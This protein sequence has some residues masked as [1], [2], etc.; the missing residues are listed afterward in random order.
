VTSRRLGVSTALVDGQ[1]VAGDVA[2]ADGVVTDVGLPAARGGRIAAPGLI[3]LQVNGFAGVDL[4]TADTDGVREVATVLAGYGVT[5]WLPTLISA[6]SRD[7]EAALDVLSSVVPRTPGRWDG[8][9]AEPLGVHLEGP[10]LSPRRLG[11]HRPEHRR[12]PDPD[13]LSGWRR[14][15]PVLAVTLAPEL[16]GALDL[17]A[18]LAAD[19]VLVSVGHTDATAEQAHAAFDAGAGTVTHLF[20]AMS[21]LNHRAPGVPGAALARPDVVVQLIVDGHH[22]APD[23]VR[24]VW[25]A[26]AGRV[27]LVTDAIAAAGRP[28]QA[29]AQAEDEYVLA[30]MSVHVQD[31][32]VRNAEGALAGSAL[33]LDRAVRNACEL[34]VD[35]AAALTAATRTPADLIG[36]RDLGRLQPGARADLVVLDD[37]LAVQDTL[38]SGRLVR[39]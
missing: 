2:V 3:D 9:G 21:P 32:A 39:R 8:A 5:A 4:M 7:T 28:A 18:G 15:G 31:G 34:G 25:A 24:T 23:V 12:D 22:L 37:S 1:L 30:G 11:T 26:A 10:Y 33:T 29:D 19:G 27:V 13:E 35:P 14:R 38:L 36:R 20:N 17:V 6:P 16:P